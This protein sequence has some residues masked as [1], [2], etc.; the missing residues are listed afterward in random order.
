MPDPIEMSPDSRAVTVA[1][2]VERLTDLGHYVSHHG[3]E[4][5]W[6]VRQVWEI[7]ARLYEALT[8]EQWPGTVPETVTGEPPPAPHPSAQANLDGASLLLIGKCV[9]RGGNPDNGRAMLDV[10]AREVAT[11]NVEVSALHSE[12]DDY[13]RRMNRMDAAIL[14]CNGVCSA[15]LDIS[16]PEAK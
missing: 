12:I 16:T 14:S 6:Q 1:K 11:L 5:W 9:E 7:V 10:A 13:H 4:G 3:R 15:L 8:G 2:C